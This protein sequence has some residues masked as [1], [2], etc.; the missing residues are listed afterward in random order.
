MRLTEKQLKR[1]VTEAANRVLQEM[2]FDA[3]KNALV[4]TDLDLANLKRRRDNGERTIKKG[5]RTSDIN[6]EIGRRERQ[7]TDFG[8][9]LGRDIASRM[10]DKDERVNRIK[11]E[12]EHCYEVMEKYRHDPD[13]L[14]QCKNELKELQAKLHDALSTNR[15]VN[16]YTPQNSTSQGYSIEY[17]PYKRPNPDARAYSNEYAHNMDYSS[18]MHTNKAAQLQGYT[19]ELFSLDDKFSGGARINKRKQDLQDRYNDSVAAQKYHDDRDRYEQ[20]KNEDERQMRQYNNLPFYKKWF[21]KKPQMHNLTKPE[22]P[23]RKTSVYD[24]P[25]PE[26]ASQAIYDYDNFVKDNYRS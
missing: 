26:Q 3:K 5:N 1:I 2:D 25:T 8:N 24:N 11:D 16:V 10:G 17:N 13:R 9:Y 23:N 12:I 18:P 22:V 21:K 14:N 15:G 4:K 19:D 6:Y 20:A 7:L